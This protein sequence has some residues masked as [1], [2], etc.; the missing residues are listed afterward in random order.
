MSAS[1]PS[2]TKSFSTKTD[3]SGQ[4][5]FAAHIND[6]QDEVVAIENG[7]LTGVVH[8]LKPSVASAQDLGS[9]SLP[10]GKARVGGLQLTDATTL[11]LAT[12]II[13]VTQS[14][15]AV[16]TESA[17][18]TDNLATITAGTGVAAGFI[19]VLRAANV[20][21]VVT[22][23]DG[24]GNLLLS[25]TCVLG[26]TDA[27]L[28]L[29][30]DGTNWREVA[31]SVSSQLTLLKSATGSDTSAAATT[32]DS[33]AIS[34]LTQ[35]DTLRVIVNVE[36]V[37]QNTA[38]VQLY[39]VTDAMNLVAVSPSPL[40]TASSTSY[41]EALFRQRNTLNTWVEA[42][43][44]GMTSSPARVD[45]IAISNTTTAWTAPWTLGLRHGGVTAGGTLRWSW[46]VYK[47]AGQ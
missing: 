10:W 12:D 23:Q 6:L 37:T 21:R 41:G 13:T 46:A 25:G 30:Y 28:T 26:S 39:S 18:A 47:L 24:T 31:R 11:T 29:I 40:S 20:A 1:Y 3:G 7:L 33:I 45:V 17:A 34:G 42:M 35:L 4:T 22:V 36:T 19:V 8:G 14:Y 15:H 27:T 9:A 16:D 5:I 43:F 32:V 2:G 38:Q 44:Q